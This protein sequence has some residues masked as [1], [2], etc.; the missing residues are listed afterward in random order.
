MLERLNLYLTESYNELKNNVEWPSWPS[1]QSTTLVVLTATLVIAAI[2]FVMD[3]VGGSIL[4]YI[5][6]LA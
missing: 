2:I 4:R 6:E 5:Y 1:L 3:A